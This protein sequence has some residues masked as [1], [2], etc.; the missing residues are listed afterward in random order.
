MLRSWVRN[1]AAMTILLSQAAQGADLSRP[2]GSAD[3]STL[4]DQLFRQARFDEAQAAYA[5][6][7]GADRRNFRAHIGMG[8]IASLLSDLR[9]ATQHFSTAYQIAPFNPDAILFFADVVEERASRNILLRNFLALAARDRDSRIPAVAARLASEEGLQ[10]RIGA[11]PCNQLESPYQPYSIPLSKQ[12]TWALQLEASINGRAP[13][14]L[15]VDTGASGITLNASS[16]RTRD[17]DFLAPIAVLGF[18][19]SKPAT[20]REALARS[21]R[22]GDLELA[23][24]LVVVAGM[25]VSQDADGVIGP[26]VFRQFLIKLNARARRLD[27]TP[28]PEPAPA[29]PRATR[30]YRINHLLLLRGKVNGASE[31]YFILDSGSRY[32]LISRDLAT[33]AGQ[34]GTIKGVQGEFTAGFPASPLNLH[35]GSREFVDFE[36][37]TLDTSEISVR[38]GTEI[39]GVLGLP[40]L[41]N[42]ALT[43]DYR[44]GLVEFASKNRD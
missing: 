2:T 35:I 31:G 41:S 21:L 27:L 43:L 18:G 13:L 37:A 12:R 6:A 5:Q 32:T 29:N 39:G 28:L 3:F 23:N 40:L 20:G 34:P 4:G 26:D 30:A 25:E 7:L 44:D 19:P 24:V 42:I 22:A 8:R 9:G 16:A 10:S 33:S 1:A 38:S 17:L 15:I 36:Y 14:H 11:A